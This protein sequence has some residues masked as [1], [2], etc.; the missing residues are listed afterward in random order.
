MYRINYFMLFLA[1]PF[2]ALFLVS[3]GF[4]DS[5]KHMQLPTT[6][7]AEQVDE[8]HN[9]IYD[10]QESIYSLGML[11]EEQQ[12]TFSEQYKDLAGLSEL[13]ASQRKL[14]DDI[15]EQKILDML[16]P[17]VAAHIS[18][19]VEI[20][21]FELA[22]LGYRGYIAKVKLFDPK[23]FKVVIAGDTL[24]ELETT[25][26]AAK[27]KGAIL[28][29]NGGGFYT[30]NRNG[31]SYAQLIGNTVVD[32]KLVEPFNGY[33]GDLFFAGINR[34]GQVIGTVP[35]TENDI[36]RLKPY[37]GV[38][39]IPVLLKDGKKVDI[40]EKW[41]ATNQ[42]RTIIGKYANDDLIMIV[43]DGRQG[44]WSIGVT[45]EHLQDK[46][47]KLGVKEAYNLDGGGSSAIYYNGKVLNKPSDGK[48]RPVA[49]N[50]V[51]LP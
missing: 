6:V 3:T 23:A 7:L 12:Q 2:L 49:N 19:R 17:A 4:A 20:K 32:G 33:P 10:L 1:A 25:S 22:E 36:M 26:S 38:S 27:R 39:F 37:Q 14:S 31:K 24:G 51:I 5:S 30:E 35:S 18:D 42:P 9:G 48:E 44:N 8:L 28:A 43:I 47:L 21:I 46:L 29:I 45:L 50:I 15:Y 16:G 41:M 40:P 11:A 13:S 34:N